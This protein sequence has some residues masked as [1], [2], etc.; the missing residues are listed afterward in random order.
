MLRF[1]DCMS[2]EAENNFK[3]LGETTFGWRYSGR[4]EENG[5]ICFFSSLNCNSDLYV[6]DVIFRSQNSV[7]TMVERHRQNDDFTLQIFYA[8]LTCGN[9]CDESVYF[10]IFIRSSVETVA[11]ELVDVQLVE[12]LWMAAQKAERTDLEFQV[13][14]E[15][16]CAHKWLVAS[17]SA[18]F[19]AQFSDLLLE[20]AADCDVSSSSEKENEDQAKTAATSTTRTTIKIDDIEPD[21]FR[22]LLKYIYTGTLSV[23][24]SQPLLVAAEKYEIESLMSMCR[25]AIHEI[26]CEN[27]SFKL[28][29]Y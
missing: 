28:L 26:N 8:N 14:D 2:N 1:T 12:S 7:I 5:H 24:A 10:E 9:D 21:T 3:F 15:V 22:E 19:A 18:S 4:T 16:F 27:L 23:T 25:A 13:S 11:V 17:R 6:C 29:S 20:E